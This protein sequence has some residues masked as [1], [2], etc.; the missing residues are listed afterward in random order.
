MVRVDIAFSAVSSQAN[1]LSDSDLETLERIAALQDQD[2]IE[3]ALAAARQRLNMD[4]AYVTAIDSGTRRVT[5]LSGDMEALGMTPGKE[6]PLEK[7]YCGRMLSG[8]IPNIVPDTSV[9]PAVKE[10][11]ATARVKAYVGVPIR[12]ADGSVHGSLCCG[13]TAPR[14]ELGDQELKFMHVLAGMVAARIE[15]ARS[16]RPPPAGSKP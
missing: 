6:V 9:E 11:P 3:R 1:S 7:T 4:A 15:Q 14:T 2:T 10:L 8:A 12:L 13:S 5:N 16:E